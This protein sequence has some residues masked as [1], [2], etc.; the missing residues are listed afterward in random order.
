MV[1]WEKMMIG[2]NM[3]K[4]T[5][6]FIMSVFALLPTFAQEIEHYEIQG[7]KLGRKIAKQVVQSELTRTDISIGIQTKYGIEAHRSRFTSFVGTA[8]GLAM[9]SLARSYKYQNYYHG[10]RGF[11]YRKSKN[12]SSDISC[13]E[14][15]N[16]TYADEDEDGTLSKDE[17]A[18]VYFDLIN[19]GSTPLYGIVPVLMADKTK[20]IQISSPMPIDTLEAESALRYVI[21]LSGDG[22]RN[23]NK[24]YLMLRIKYGDNKY[25]DIEQIT[26]GT[27]RKVE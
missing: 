1:W 9:G 24:L 21:E 10:E 16:I 4:M 3:K 6:V 19:T 25:I 12:Q 26:L 17:T 15:A 13:L 11:N 23:P 18:Q 20:H 27:K 2:N 5:I 14:I 8:D 7:A 22:K